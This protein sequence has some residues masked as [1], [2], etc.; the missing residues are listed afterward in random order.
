VAFGGV[1]RRLLQPLL[2][3][4]QGRGRPLLDDETLWPE[5]LEL[6]QALVAPWLEQT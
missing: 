3:E 2:L 5:A 4:A 1:A 6:A